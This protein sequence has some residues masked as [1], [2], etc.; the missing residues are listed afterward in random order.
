MSTRVEQLEKRIEEGV[1][2]GMREFYATRLRALVANGANKAAFDEFERRLA[3][4]ESLSVP[5]RYTPATR[6]R[7]GR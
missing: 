2:P 1:A 4:A 3:I 7:T 5:R 6:L